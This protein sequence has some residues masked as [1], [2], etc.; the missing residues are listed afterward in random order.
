MIKCQ[1]AMMCLRPFE[2]SL[3]L[4]S[5]HKFMNISDCF[6]SLIY[7]VITQ[8]RTQDPEKE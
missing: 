8:R 3:L 2:T 6:V 5:Q 4:N 1:K 7:S